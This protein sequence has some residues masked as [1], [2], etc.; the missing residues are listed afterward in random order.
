VANQ[1]SMP[2]AIED[3]LGQRVRQEREVRGW[4]QNELA[5]RLESIGIKLHFSAIAK[6]EARDVTT[7]RT[8]R[9]AEA[10]ALAAV[11]DM[12]L[13]ELL[14]AP[15]SASGDLL[16]AVRDSGDDIADVALA[17]SRIKQ[18]VSRLQEQLEGKPPATPS[19]VVSDL[20]SALALMPLG[21]V[22]LVGVTQSLERVIEQVE[23]LREGLA[24]TGGAQ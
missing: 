6:M 1:R 14:D 3:R 21:V 17:V 7:P 5:Q 18:S 15:R 13:E 24:G 9:L 22:D 2:W 19:A 4:S 16:R 23:A 11:F 12:T 8:F 20:E 10:W